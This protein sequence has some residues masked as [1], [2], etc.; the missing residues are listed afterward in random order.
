MKM[1]TKS[2]ISPHVFPS[3]VACKIGNS[4]LASVSFLNVGLLISRWCRMPVPLFAGMGCTLAN[5]FSLPSNVVYF[6][7]ATL[8]NF[9]LS[10]TSTVRPHPMNR[11]VAFMPQK[12]SKQFVRGSGLTN[13]RPHEA[14]RTENV[15]AIPSFPSCEGASEENDAPLETDGLTT[16]VLYQ[17]ARREAIELECG[18]ERRRK[19]GRPLCCCGRTCGRSSCD[20]RESDGGGETYTLARARVLRKIGRR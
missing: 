6:V 4:L 17:T 10:N 15:L 14:R 16:D 19:E 13:R 20:L 12:V 11:E 18:G 1:W 7:L 9:T 2:S 8:L 5:V 3:D